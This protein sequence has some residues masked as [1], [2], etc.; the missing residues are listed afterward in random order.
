MTT[1]TIGNLAIKRFVPPDGNFYNP[2][3][4]QMSEAARMTERQGDER[5]AYGLI[6]DAPPPHLNIINGQVVDT[7]TMLMCSRCCCWKKD[8]AFARDRT[9]SIRRGRRYYC[10]D[11]HKH[12]R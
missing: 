9:R 1:H 4:I 10:V 5:I 12:M 6:I 3:R 7:D 8:S 2:D 11:C